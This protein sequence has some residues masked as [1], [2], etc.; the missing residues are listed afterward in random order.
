MRRKMD[1]YE[2][3]RQR[4]AAG[5]ASADDLGNVVAR[6]VSLPGSSRSGEKA[7]WKP[8]GRSARETF[9][10]RGLPFSSSGTTTSSVVPG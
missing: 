2:R 5:S 6:N 10:P 3:R 4:S 9:K 1:P 7:T 8:A